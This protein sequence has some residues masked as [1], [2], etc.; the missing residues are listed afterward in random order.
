M[1]SALAA[2]LL[3]CSGVTASAQTTVFNAPF[4]SDGSGNANYSA[5]IVIP[6]ISAGGS[7]I[8]ITVGSDTTGAFSAS[9]VSVCVQASAQNC[10]AAPV[11]VK[12]GLSS[13]FSNPTNHGPLSSDW[14]TF[15]SLAGQSLLVILD[16]TSSQTPKNGSGTTYLEPNANPELEYRRA[17]RNMALLCNRVRPDQGGSAER[18][19]T[20]RHRHRRH[21]QT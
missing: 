15:D 19:T 5:R 3:L 9:H 7:Q 8:R 4:Q 21:R 17:G 6:N 16:V 11:E 13:G 2:I 18:F 14:T 20:P 1:K 10:Q 12:F